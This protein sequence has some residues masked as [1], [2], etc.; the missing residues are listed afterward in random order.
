MGVEC[1]KPY[2]NDGKTITLKWHSA[3]DTHIGLIV[4]MTNNA[5]AVVKPLTIKGT[6]E[7]VT[8]GFL[9]EIKSYSDILDDFSSNM[10]G[11]NNELEA[12][13]KLKET[14]L[15]KAKKEKA[16][17]C[18]NT[19]RLTGELDMEMAQA[20]IDLPAGDAN[21]KSKCKSASLT[22][23][24]RALELMTRTGNKKKGNWNKVAAEIKTITGKGIAA[25]GF[26]GDTAVGQP[27]RL[28]VDS[29]EGGDQFSNDNIDEGETGY[30]EEVEEEIEEEEN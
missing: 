4:T 15:Q 10:S 14:E 2:A 24:L 29:G 27:A 23:L 5:G 28:F 13:K 22:T 12:Q 26:S 20:L 6:Y 25:Y 21:F 18:Q 9:K 1:F 30:T 16:V 19:S 7:E 17:S 11:L 8:A 3:T